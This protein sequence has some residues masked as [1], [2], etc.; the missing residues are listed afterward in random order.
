[1]PKKAKKGQKRPKKAK[2]GQKRPKKSKKSEKFHKSLKNYRT[3]FRNTNRTKPRPNASFFSGASFGVEKE[4][5]EV[6]EEKLRGF[7]VS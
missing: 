1:M 3:L 4:R 2:K 5:K 6:L 7:K